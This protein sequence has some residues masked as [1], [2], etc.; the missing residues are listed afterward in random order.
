M[1]KSPPPIRPAKAS[2]MA[3]IAALYGEEVRLG[4]GTFELDPPDEAEMRNRFLALTGASYPYLVAAES[5]RILG[6]AYAGFFRARPAYRFTVEDSVYVAG[7]AR[8][9]GIGGAL[10]A[11]L[12]AESEARGFRQMVAVIGDSAN[13]ASIAL[14]RRA[15]FLAAGSLISAGWKLGRW[16][17][18]VLMQ[19]A[20]GAGAGTPPRE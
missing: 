15:G 12:I 6:F 3:A 17:D 14:H 11:A 13:V 1:K 8:V 5:G 16:I 19:R 18:A 7:D 20:L 4:T 9:R 2:D 10:L